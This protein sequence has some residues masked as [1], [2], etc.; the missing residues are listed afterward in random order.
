M[1]WQVSEA[2]SPADGYPPWEPCFKYSS[3]SRGNAMATTKR[4]VYSRDSGSHYS[5]ESAS[6][7]SSNLT[8]LNAVY[9][10]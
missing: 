10:K 5:Y 8:M 4:P 1:Q 9:S 3:K 6:H 2:D 7:G